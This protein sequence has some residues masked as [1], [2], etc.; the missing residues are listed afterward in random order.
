MATYQYIF[1]RCRLLIG[2]RENYIGNGFSIER[3]DDSQGNKGFRV[4]MGE[5]VVDIFEFEQEEIY[6]HNTHE[7]EVVERKNYGYYPME[8]DIEGSFILSALVAECESR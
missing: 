7:W 1:S 4:Y 6:N 3:V 8:K 2:D 5:Y